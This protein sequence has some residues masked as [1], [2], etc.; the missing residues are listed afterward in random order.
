MIDIIIF[1]GKGVAFLILLKFLIEALVGRIMIRR[2]FKNSG[3][4]VLRIRRFNGFAE[5][6]SFWRAFTCEVYDV[7]ILKQG[8]KDSVVVY[9]TVQFIPPR[10]EADVPS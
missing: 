7:T 3:Y 8:G 10:V 4:T 5:L 9:C 1:L 6:G 2:A